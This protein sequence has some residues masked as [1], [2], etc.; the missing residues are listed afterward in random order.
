LRIKELNNNNKKLSQAKIF[1]LVCL[2]MQLTLSQLNN[3][4]RL[5]TSANFSHENLLHFAFL[6]ADEMSI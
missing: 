3:I 1:M 6:F 4:Q 2:L 5:A